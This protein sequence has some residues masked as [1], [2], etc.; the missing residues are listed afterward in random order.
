MTR[1]DVRV[2]STRIHF[3]GLVVY[4][5]GRNTAVATRVSMRL[6]RKQRPKAILERVPCSYGAYAALRRDTTFDK[7]DVDEQEPEEG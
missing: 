5:Y 4:N 1:L 6:F 3:F 7:V 2:D